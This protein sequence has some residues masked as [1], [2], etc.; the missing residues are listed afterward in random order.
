[1]SQIV[2]QRWTRIIRPKKKLFDVDLKSV[3]RY[4]DL[5]YMYVKRDIVVQYK[6]TIL[7]P[8][9]YFVQP[10]MTTIMFMFVF[11][12]IANI[13]TDG[14]PQPLFYMAGL[15]L[16]NYFSSCFT[17]SSDI[18]G[19]N[20]AVFGKVYFPRLVVP[21][22]AIVSN[23][24]KMLIQ[25]ALF[26]FLYVFYVIKGAPVYL[27]W[28]LVLFPLLVV[29]VALHGMSMGLIISS[30][31]TKYRDLKFLI[32]FGV[33]L[34]MYATPVIYPLSAS[35]EKYRWLLEINPLTPILE[36]FKYSCMGC[37][38]LNWGGLLYSFIFMVIMLFFGVVI[39]SRQERNFMDT[40]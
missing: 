36:A 24:L 34:L 23:L 31:T 11:G 13:S 2:E 14:M 18:F 6:Q 20:A 38:A 39:F 4:R 15:L 26:V 27:N 33:Q 22:S 1:M 16:W 21:L 5:V 19:G 9:W 17:A 32:S 7:G 37:G 35:P 10:I 25:L 30:L 28:T 8:L 3:W 29:M 12:G 40:V